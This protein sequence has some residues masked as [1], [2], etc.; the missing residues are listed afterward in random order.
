MARFMLFALLLL[1]IGG[2]AFAGGY[3][4]GGPGGIALGAFLGAIGLMIFVGKVVKG[5]DRRSGA[6]TGS[7]SF[8]FIKKILVGGFKL[9][10]KYWKLLRALLGA[11][12]VV[13]IL[14]ELL[15]MLGG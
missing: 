13:A 10:R 11:L 3:F 14:N 6:D 1:T 2:G 8:E 12:I 7:Q 5:E 4:I 9:A 15:R